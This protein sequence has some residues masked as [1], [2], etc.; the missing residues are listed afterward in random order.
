LT[1]RA[2]G[3]SS[4][5]MN[6]GGEGGDNGGKRTD[7]GTKKKKL[8][9]NEIRRPDDLSHQFGIGGAKQDGGRRERKQTEKTQVLKK[10]NAGLA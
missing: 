7:R 2:L 5:A 4:T 8:R 6:L 9:H 3:V 1:Y 10:A